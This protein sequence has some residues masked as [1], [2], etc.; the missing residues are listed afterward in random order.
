MAAFL[1]ISANNENVLTNVRETFG[2]TDYQPTAAPFTTGDFRRQLARFDRLL[3]FPKK[4]MVR[5]HFHNLCIK[6]K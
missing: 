3:Y 6:E 5:G 2:V 4:M 1:P